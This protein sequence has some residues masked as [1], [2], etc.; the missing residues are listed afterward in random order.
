[1]EKDPDGRVGGCGAQLPSKHVKNSL[2]VEQFL[3]KTNQKLVEDLL[4]NQS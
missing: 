4:Y 2:H 3:H 1:M